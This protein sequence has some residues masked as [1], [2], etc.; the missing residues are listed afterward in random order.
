MENIENVKVLY[1]VRYDDVLTKAKV[2]CDLYGVTMVACMV[3]RHKSRQSHWTDARWVWTRFTPAS[4][5]QYKRWMALQAISPVDI[6]AIFMELTHVLANY[7]YHNGPWVSIEKEIPQVLWKRSVTPESFIH[8]P[9]PYRMFLVGEQR[10]GS[11]NVHLACRPAIRRQ[12]TFF[13][14][15]LHAHGH[16]LSE[17]I[18][19]QS[20]IE[21]A[22]K[23]AKLMRVI[24][25]RLE[26]SSYQIE[27]K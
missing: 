21:A 23:M 14:V 27:Q 24:K 13:P 7:L 12:R 20:P 2:Q 5:I 17:S 25:A 22:E 3:Y 18:A 26:M 4:R 1:P 11:V 8:T 9:T 6:S 15:T 19:V 10:V 16:I